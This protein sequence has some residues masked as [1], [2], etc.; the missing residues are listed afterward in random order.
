MFGGLRPAESFR[1]ISIRNKLYCIVG[2]MALLIGVELAALFFSL[3]TLSSVRAYV[4][5]EGLWS[6][7][8]KDAAF[9]LYRYGVSHNE[10]D[11]LLFQN[12]MTVLE[13]DGAARQQLFKSNPDIAMARRGFIRGRNHP[14]DID[15][16]IRL[17]RDF[18]KTFYI[19]KAIAIWAKG[20]QT[21]LQLTPIADDLRRELGSKSP[22]RQHI[23]RLLESI[24]PI[25]A[26]L[27]AL[28]DNFSYTLGEGSRWLER[29][30]RRLLFSIALT[31]ELTGLLL[32][33]SISRQIR[34]GLAEII[35]T[36]SA[37]ASGRYDMRARVLSKDETGILAAS[38][39]AMAD[40]LQ[41]SILALGREI[42]E[43]ERTGA[44]L[45]QAFSLLERHVNNTPLAIIEWEQNYS[46]GE[47]P[48]VR[49]WSGRAQAIFGWTESNMLGRRADEFRL[50]HEGD[51]D[52]AY[53]A[54]RDLAEHQ[55]PHNTVSLRCYTNQGRVLHCRWYNSAVH[56]GDGNI[57][58]LSLVEDVSE[59]VAAL[60][61]VHRLAH[62]DTLTGLPNRILLQDRLVQALAAARQSR[63]RLAVMMLDLDRFKSIN[64][65]LGHSIGDELLRDVARR[66]RAKLLPSDT[67]ARVGG[68]EFVII[69]SGSID[70]VSAASGARQLIDVLAEP[71]F[72]QGNR[73]DVGASIGVTLYPLDAAGSDDLLRKA[74]IALYRA[75][76]D[77]G[78][79]CCIYSADM[80]LEMTH[81]RSLETG[82]RQALDS[83]TI[84]LFYQPTFALADGRV[85]GLEALARWPHP[86]GGF[87]SP[88][89]FIPIAEMSG[90]IV[91]LGEWALR[92]ACRQAKI[93]A[94]EGW[95]ARVAVNVSAVQLRQSNFAELVEGVLNE[96]HLA[97]SVLELEVTEGVFLDPSKAAITK[98][99][100]QVAEIGVSLA[101]DDF[102]T[103]YSSLNY[104]KHFSFDRIK[105]DRSFVHDI[106]AGKMADAIIEAIIRLGHGLGKL[107]TAEG[108][109]TEFQLDFLR[110]HKCDDV[111]GFLFGEPKSAAETVVPT[112]IVDGRLRCACELNA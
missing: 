21:A 69:R 10:E 105:I 24:E 88:A 83:K 109:E 27:T 13:G 16:M 95:N 45:R 63:Q 7:A 46:A 57:G 53:R 14:D 85:R 87:V 94:A 82:L 50:I 31:V 96:N 17:F 28:E 34:Q 80:D 61:A 89:E 93:W 9:H 4:G 100:H 58:I 77:G 32:T 90:F 51:T 106:G 47:P 71:F 52:R 33:V 76:R 64:D 44:E 8:E 54:G 3:S 74:D 41:G 2:T 110:R 60:E 55:V 86:R 65:T 25:D 49:R 18:G 36:A 98:T 91:T 73:V 22:S 68:D 99:L 20:E 97:A 70:Q 107:V 62:H 78:G 26:R 59:Q 12:F 104:L 37:F 67:L 108:V 79:Q 30:V 72:I 39:N 111:Q 15:G 56:S 23:E 5:G 38:F 84:E 1:N 19:A 40:R 29:V 66:L 35:R 75:K 103:G 112:M 101:I 81:I 48:R 42:A 6:K 102:G 43:R 92:Q 11:Y